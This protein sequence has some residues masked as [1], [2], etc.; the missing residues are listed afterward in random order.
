MSRAKGAARAVGKLVKNRGRVWLGDYL[1]GARRPSRDL[2]TDLIFVVTDHYEP[3][4][5]LGEEG[6][7]QVHDWLERFAA[8]ASRYPDDSGRPVQHTWFYRY[9]YPNDACVHPIARRVRE[10]LGELEFHLHHGH[11]T[12]ETF[13]DK[14]ASGLDWFSRHGAM[15]TATEAP[16]SRFAYIAGNWALDNGAGDDALSGCDDEIEILADLGC[17]A[18]FTFPA[19][20]SRSQPRLANRIFYAREDGRSYSHR[21]GVEARVGLAEREDLL[22]FQGPLHVDWRRGEIEYAS[23][24]HFT[25]F[26]PERLDYWRHANIHVDGRPEWLFVK[27]HTHGM[28]S[29]D[30]FLGEDFD[31][32]MQALRAYCDAEGLRLHYATAREAYNIATAAM[33]GRDGNAGDFRDY[34][35]PPPVNRFI[36]ADAPMVIDRCG[37]SIAGRLWPGAVGRSRI[38]DPRDDHWEV[39]GPVD[40]CVMFD[41]DADA[42]LNVRVESGSPV[43]ARR[44]NERL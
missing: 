16:A 39:T 27:L 13:R 29:R 22:I 28:Q 41:W 14:I 2:T 36:W 35:V 42:G 20:K 12:S 18:D 33:D 26:R 32:R 4:R 23:L 6:V 25:P 40:E 10:G 17:Y 38:I 43:D 19:F 31:T 44:L 24:E 7:R 37:T 11:D 30:H 1:F 34:R 9:D 3:S 15:R 8:K 21:S 5:R